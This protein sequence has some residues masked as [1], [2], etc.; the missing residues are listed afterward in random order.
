MLY[1]VARLENARAL[2][3]FRAERGTREAECTRENAA[4]EGP[5]RPEGQRQAVAH[6]VGDG[7]ITPTALVGTANAV[8]VTERR[9]TTY[10]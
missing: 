10:V 3:F 6:R 8:G 9:S 5:S 2:C 7:Y 1:F 4:D